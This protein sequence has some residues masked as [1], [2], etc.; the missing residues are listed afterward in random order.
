MC[1]IVGVY[2]FNHEPIPAEVL[3]RMV[4]SLVH[5]GPDDTGLIMADTARHVSSDPRTFDAGSSVLGL[6]SRRLKIIDLTS[7]GHQPMASA[8]GALWLVF[9]GEIYNYL[10]L[11]N[12]L[13]TK[14]YSFATNTDSEVILYAYHAWGAACFK[15]FNGMWAI[16]IYDRRDGSLILS[17]DRFGIKP[18]YVYRDAQRLV[19]GSE[20][21]ALRFHPAVPW[22]PNF[23]TI[24]NY[25]A[26]H[27]RWVENNRQT[28]FAGIEQLLPGHYWT[29]DARGNVAEQR[30]WDIDP[31]RRLMPKSDVEVLAQFRELLEDAVRVRL[32]SDVPVAYLLSGGL[33]SASVTALATQLTQSPVSTF[34]AR[35]AQKGS[36]EGPYIEA[37]T[38]HIGAQSRNVYPEPAALVD[39]LSTMLRF[40]DEPIC[41]PTWFAHWALMHTVAQHGFPV[42]LNGHGGDELFAG[43]WDHYLY[44]FLDLEQSDPERFKQEFACWQRNHGR[45]PQEYA[46]LKSRLAAVNEAGLEESGAISQYFSTVTASGQKVAVP[47]SPG[48]YT[49]T[50]TDEFR[51]AFAAPL[52]RRNPFG[53]SQ[54][55]ASRL[56]RDF[57]YETLPPALRPEDRN[58]M[59]FSIESR[60][61]FMDYRIVEFAFALPNHYKIRHGL[62]KW[63]I[64]E[65]MKDLL[66][67]VLLA[68]M[69]K[70]GFNVP[71]THWFRNEI[72]DSVR[73][74]LAAP[75]LAQRG[76]L[77]QAEVLRYFDA[78]VAGQGNYYLGIWQWLNL[79]L[80]LR[81]T[82][83]AV[84]V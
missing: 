37:M 28:F 14:G 46:R 17:R 2:H 22:A 23:H 18:L 21:K 49:T 81:Q 84:T 30:Y 57:M 32:R 67:G 59:A 48:D 73:E 24:Y 8:D 34:S 75:A 72:R 78:H 47:Y 12:E 50:V 1:G 36:D 80:W 11:R 61:P 66:P 65:S 51:S 52:E 41:T 40:H 39:T 29:I 56:Y 45:D 69:D 33:D 62:G 3:E 35:F 79:E 70:Q 42:L 83:D 25:V 43:Y 15:R 20:A 31:D 44:N 16:A 77:D 74:I 76:I 4:G 82:F 55:L 7:A 26:R 9:N 60:S 10:E 27:Y 63:V 71:S 13:V 38:R 19:F 58:S 5:R 64:R 54:Q 68:R 6:A 53:E